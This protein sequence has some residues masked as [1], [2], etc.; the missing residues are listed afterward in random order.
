MFPFSLSLGANASKSKSTTQTTGSFSK[1]STPL[2]PD[3]ALAPVREAA[4]RVGDLFGLDPA[5]VAAPVNPLQLQA[6]EGARG[7]RDFSFNYDSAADLTR[8]AADTSWLKPYLEADAPS[9]ASAVSSDYLG[10]YLN[11]YLAQVVDA[12]AADFDAHAGQV[13]AQQSLDL[14]GSG[15]FGGSGAA[16]TQ[17]LTEGELARAR[18]TT[19]SGLRSNAFTTALA[20]AQGDADRVTQTRQA[21]AQLAQQ[22]QAQKAGFGFQ[23]QQQQ[24]QAAG[25]LTGLSDAYNANL[26]ANVATQAAVGDALRNADGEARAAPLVTTAQIVAMLNNLPLSLFTGSTESGDDQQYSVSTTKKKGVEASFG[27]SYSG[28]T[29]P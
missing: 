3:W 26:R 5:G 11:P 20:A 2:A 13:R 15:A 9:A 19:L 18:A 12:S 28:G 4:A 1:T 22:T 25:Q 21:N 7:L 14:A 29:S 27:G 24:L 10:K 17:S 8:G 23:A 6:A 16:L